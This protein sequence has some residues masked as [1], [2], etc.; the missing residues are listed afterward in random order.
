MFFKLNLPNVIYQFIIIIITLFVCLWKHCMFNVDYESLTLKLSLPVLASSVCFDCKVLNFSHARHTLNFKGGKHDKII[1]C[2]KIWM[3]CKNK[4][5][6]SKLR[7]PW[8]DM[9]IKK[10]KAK[11]DRYN[12][13]CNSFPPISN[14][15]PWFT[16]LVS[17]IAICSFNLHN[18][19]TR[20]TTPLFL[21]HGFY[22]PTGE[23]FTVMLTSP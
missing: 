11:V 21:L 7:K 23:F 18:S 14:S 20:I 2:I 13:L 5:W 15:F 1:C 17:Q 3:P 10:Q 16:Y 6:G 19:F 22:R 9:G 4:L 12:K 8:R